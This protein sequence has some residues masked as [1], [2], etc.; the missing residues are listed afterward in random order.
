MIKMQK[1]KYSS[2]ITRL[3]YPSHHLIWVQVEDEYQSQPRRGLIWILE[4][5]SL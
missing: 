2:A 3:S 5:S 1:L 4:N